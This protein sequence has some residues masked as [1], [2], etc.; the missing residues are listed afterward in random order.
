MPLPSVMAPNLHGA[1][2]IPSYLKC[3]L[4]KFGLLITGRVV[5]RAEFGSISIMKET[6]GTRNLMQVFVTFDRSQW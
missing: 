3:P 2:V 1:F 4:S 6:R 5:K